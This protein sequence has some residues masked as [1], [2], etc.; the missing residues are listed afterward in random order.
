MIVVI[1]LDAIPFVFK[2]K[3]EAIDFIDSEPDEKS[4]FTLWLISEDCMHPL[5]IVAVR[6]NLSMGFET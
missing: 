3:R 2:T 1:R 4:N 5:D 6:Y